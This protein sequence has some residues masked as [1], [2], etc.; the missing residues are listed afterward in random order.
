MFTWSHNST[1][2]RSGKDATH[3]SVAQNADLIAALENGVITER[4]DNELMEQNGIYYKLVSMQVAFLIAFIILLT[5][6]L[7]GLNCSQRYFQLC[8]VFSV[9]KL[10]RKKLP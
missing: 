4:V 7:P 2:S 1:V 8:S 9:K 3:S 5:I 6:D 10:Q